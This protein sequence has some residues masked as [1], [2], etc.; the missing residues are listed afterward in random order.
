MRTPDRKL[1]PNQQATVQPIDLHSMTPSQRPQQTSGRAT[2]SSVEGQGS[3][4]PAGTGLDDQLEWATEQAQIYREVA[5]MNPSNP[6]AALRADWLAK[7][8]ERL[9]G[10]P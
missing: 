9:R 4:C 3:N 1:P 6:S 8:A 2:S 7:I 5:R 10:A